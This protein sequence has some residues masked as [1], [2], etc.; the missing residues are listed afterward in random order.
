MA[1]SMINMRTFDNSIVKIECHDRVDSC[2]DIA[3][4][5]AKEGYADKYAVV[6]KYDHKLGGDD[7]G[8]YM[9]LLL[10]P[11]F[12]P[13]QAGLLSALSVSAFAKALAEHTEMR[14]GIGWV[15]SIY[16]EGKHIGGVS[17]EGKLGDMN[18]YEYIIINFAVKLSD[19]DF[20]PRLTDL[21]KRIFENDNHSITAIIAKNILNKFFPL[22]ANMRSSTKFMQ[23]YKQRFVLT[24]HR[25]KRIKNGKR[26]SPRVL[27]IRTEDCALLLEAKNAPFDVVTSP[28]E[29]II[30]KSIKLPK[31]PKKTGII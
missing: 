20:P 17:V 10:R 19:E 15:S 27:G 13:S 31:P 6:S 30:P 4:E 24:G 21:V 22:Y 14:I 29:V 28:T 26:S 18:G 11:S 8:I 16:C 9:S 7:K 2:Q 5:Y 23:T 1:V 25:V 3:R 12:F